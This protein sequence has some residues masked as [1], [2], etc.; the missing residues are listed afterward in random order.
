[1]GHLVYPLSFKGKV[2]WKLK[3]ETKK[4]GDKYPVRIRNL[5]PFML[6]LY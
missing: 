1:M 4:V 2:I 6:F 5:S 3:M